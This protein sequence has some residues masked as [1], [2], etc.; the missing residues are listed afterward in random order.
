MENSNQKIVYVPL[1]V[2]KKSKEYIHP[3]SVLAN[4]GWTFDKMEADN[5][6]LPDGVG[7]LAVEGHYDPETI[8]KTFKN[9]TYNCQS[10]K[11]D[12]VPHIPTQISNYINS[13]YTKSIETNKG[14]VKFRELEPQVIDGV[15]YKFIK[16][17]GNINLNGF[18]SLNIYLKKGEEDVS[19][20]DTLEKFLNF[21][22]PIGY[23]LVDYAPELGKVYTGLTKDNLIKYLK[24]ESQR[25]DQIISELQAR[26]SALKE[27]ILPEAIE[28]DLDLSALLNKEEAP[29][30]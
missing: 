3:H 25:K 21:E 23:G 8:S 15:T 13:L 22:L 2:D 20:I 6:E 24:E 1:L 19:K 14:Y 17:P 5:L 10:M 28:G 29:R 7:W 30:R 11:Y 9:D 16:N 4:V 26:E 18:T 27:R 12:K